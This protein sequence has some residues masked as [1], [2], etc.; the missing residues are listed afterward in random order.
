M[1]AEAI[2]GLVL[3]RDQ[4][5]HFVQ[6]RVN[7]PAI[8]E[9][10]IQSAYIRAIE[11]APALRKEE[12]AVTWFYRILRNTAPSKT[13]L[14]SSGHKTSQPALHSTLKPR[15]SSAVAS[16]RYCPPSS[17]PTARFSVA[18]T[19]PVKASKPSPP[20]RESLRET[21]P[22]AFIGPA[23][24]SK[25]NSSA[26]AAPAPNSRA[27]TVPAIERNSPPRAVFLQH[28]QSVNFSRKLP[29]FSIRITK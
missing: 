4:F 27:P 28:S 3:Q 9:D 29:V 16:A 14:S 19:S 20:K 6:R 25:R 1:Q 2:T 17:L 26:F 24:P 18:S 21:R 23:R 7:S 11:H 12:S 22:S 10:I 8:A 15:G 13:M 5:L